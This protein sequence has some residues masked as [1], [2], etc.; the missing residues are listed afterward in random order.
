M[1]T[2]T[3]QPTVRDVFIDSIKYRATHEG[4]HNIHNGH[5]V[6]TLEIIGKRGKPLS[7]RRCCLWDGERYYRL[8]RWFSM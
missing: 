2:A 5:E 4:T 7:R 8:S 6:V 1:T 3:T